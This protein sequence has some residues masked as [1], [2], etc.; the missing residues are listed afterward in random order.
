MRSSPRADDCVM[1][2]LYA[3]LKRFSTSHTLDVPGLKPASASL[4]LLTFTRARVKIHE[5]SSL[6]R[7]AG[8]CLDV[9]RILTLTFQL[10]GAQNR[11]IAL[12]LSLA[13]Y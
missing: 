12:T 3:F 10:S 2:R 1:S 9:K 7:G 8:H 13:T 5:V 6:F 4:T 11:S